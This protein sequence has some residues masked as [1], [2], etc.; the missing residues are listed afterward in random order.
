MGDIK[1]KRPG[2]TWFE[3]LLFEQLPKRENVDIGCA[4]FY[5]VQKEPLFIELPDWYAPEERA[6][7][8]RKLRKRL[9]GTKR[10]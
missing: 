9:Y 1:R 10:L 2:L 3:Q 7:K 6:C 5:V 8:V 4:Y